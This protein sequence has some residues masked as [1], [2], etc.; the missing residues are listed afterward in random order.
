MAGSCDPF[1]QN[2]KRIAARS[3]LDIY[4][5]VDENN[6]F[7]SIG[8]VVAWK[9]DENPPRSI[10]SVKDD[11]DFWRGIFAHKRIDRSDVSLVV[12]RYDWTPGA[13]YTAYRDNIDLFDDLNPAPFYALVDEERVYKC[14]DNASNSPSL[15]A[16]MHTD[17]RIRRLSDGYRWKFLYQIPESKR[18][19]LTKTQGD[20][21]GYMPVEFVEYLRTNDERILQWRVQEDAVDGEIAF[22]KMNTD[23]QPFVVSTNCVFPSASNTV[24]A[25]VALGATGIT[26]ASKFLFLQEGYY[27]DMV[28]S[29]DNGQGLGQRRVI[30][31]F[32]PTDGSSAFVTV[33]DPFSASVSGG[34]SPSTFSI[35]PYIKVVGDGEA[36]VNTSNPYST[37][38]EVSVRFG[39]TAGSDVLGANGVTSCT[40]FFETIRLIDSI[41]L[42]DGGKNYTFASLEFVKGLD[43]PTGKVFLRDLAEPVMS[44]PNGHGSDPVK[45]LGA[46]SI[47]IVKDYFRSENEKVS[48]ENEYRQFGLLLNPLLEEK[49]VRLNFYGSGVSG[50]F[51]A[52][53]TAQQATGAGYSGAYGKIVSWRSGASGQSGTSELVLTNIKNGDFKF[54]GTVNGLTIINIREKTVAGTEGRR[55]LRL[56][57]APTNAAFVGN[58][59]DFTEG[60]IAIGVGNYETS[61]PPS[62]ASGE[63]Y[64]WEPS[65]GSNK[66]GYLYLEESQGNF[67]QGERLT[68]VTPLYGGFVGTGLSGVAEI[69]AIDSVI[70]S[71]TAHSE[72]CRS[73]VPTSTDGG[74]VYDQTTSLV[75]SYDGNNQFDSQSFRE[76][77]YTEF[78]YGNTGSANGYVMDWSAGAS[79]TTGTLRVTG[80]QGK[81]YVGMTTPYFVDE[82]TTASAQVQQIVHTG[83]LK[84]R[85]GETLYIQNMKPIQRGFEQ[86]E[87]IKIVIDF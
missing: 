12:R 63:V 72:C 33:A 83:E 84:Y 35:V 70:R 80:T 54:G 6:L 81:F 45:E 76:D 73:G 60:Y 4:G 59:T 16:P 14:I 31:S 66:S 36:N 61:T 43:V 74:S 40:E 37:N 10:D 82:S 8:K 5:D 71:L 62:R 87:E 29:I 22:I 58:G 23:V 20:S 64:A 68:Q 79:G 3:L 67:K 53:A 77:D 30:T 17:S 46:S 48:T 34:G 18:K 25:N 55:L 49:H 11:T 27:E 21:I 9:D 26:L 86:K 75:V 51:V 24:V 69:V 32:T 15:V 41:E 47:M 39:L 56:R 50:S 13:V 1:R 7:L 65:L 2:H 19:F 52:G 42:V 78:A 28:L 85:S 38:A 44:P 57:V